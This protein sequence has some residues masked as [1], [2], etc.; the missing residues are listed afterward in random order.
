MTGVSLGCDGRVLRCDGF[1][2]RYRVARHPYPTADGGTVWRVG[3]EVPHVAQAEK[4][5]E[6]VDPPSPETLERQRAWV[7]AERERARVK[8][9]H[10]AERARLKEEQEREEAEQLQSH[11]A[12]AA[13]K[14]EREAED[15]LNC[16]R[17]KV[18]AIRICFKGFR[19]FFRVLGF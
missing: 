17:A 1:V 4:K 11:R 18:A 12:K 7:A 15:K 3:C 8:K 13:A 9:E 6:E 16:H 5:C 10:E 19:F 2:A 14:R